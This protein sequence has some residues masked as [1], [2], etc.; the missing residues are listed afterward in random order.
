MKKCTYCGL[1]NPD[2]AVMCGT[3][4][5]EFVAPSQSSPSE[6]SCAHLISPEEK[7]FW[8]QMTFRQFAIL[9]IRLQALW[10]LFDAVVDSTY[11]PRYF[12][13]FLSNSSFYTLSPE[14]RFEAFLAVLRVIMHVAAA[15]ALIQYAERVLSWLVKDSVPKQ[16]PNTAL[17]PTTTA[18]SDSSKT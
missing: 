12:R 1:E 18:P 13:G 2:E 3:C 8:E 15:V 9:I 5:T 14:S 10:L 17:E 16:S 4:H 7:R 11:L 6:P